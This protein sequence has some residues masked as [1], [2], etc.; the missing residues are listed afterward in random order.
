[1]PTSKHNFST[2]LHSFVEEKARLFYEKKFSEHADYTGQFSADK[3]KDSFGRKLKD[4]LEA[5]IGLENV[6]NHRTLINILRSGFSA[7]AQIST[8]NNFSRF[9]GYNDFDTF[10]AQNPLAEKLPKPIIIES[11]KVIKSYKNWALGMPLAAVMAFGAWFFWPKENTDETKIRT[12]IKTANHA[13]FEAFKSCP[14]CD[15]ASMKPYYLEE[16]SAYKY[17]AAALQNVQKDQRTIGQPKDNP[18]Y[19]SIE[20]IYEVKIT[21]TEAVA[22]TAEFWLLKWYDTKQKKYSKKYEVANK[23]SYKMLKQKGVWKILDNNY[24][25]N[26]VDL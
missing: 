10:C 25:G 23:Q 21:G 11:Q 15:M 14:D 3:I 1:M 7:N 2:V 20:E 4:Y 9:V 12:L 13:Q 17:L 6:I 24:I 22:R 18:S 5:E 16:G 8:L 19:F 26:A